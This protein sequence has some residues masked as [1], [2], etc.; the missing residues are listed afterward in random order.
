MA[1]GDEMFSERLY[2]AEDRIREQVN[3]FDDKASYLLVILTFLADFVEHLRFNRYLLIVVAAAI[4]ISALCAIFEL[5]VVRYRAEDATAYEGYRKEM[6]AANSGLS[7]TALDS[8]MRQ[9]MMAATK[10]RILKNE[11]INRR[12]GRLL[13]ISYGAMLLALLISIGKM[14]ANG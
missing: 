12:K 2:A 1:T 7:D 4:C 11:L 13:V 6:K 3:G 8:A 10:A 9:G 5:A 14:V